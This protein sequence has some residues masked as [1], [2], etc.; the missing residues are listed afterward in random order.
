MTETAKKNKKKKGKEP[1][2]TIE[3][4]YAKYASKLPG[5]RKGYNV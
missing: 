2:W 3:D 4:N 1:D 5:E